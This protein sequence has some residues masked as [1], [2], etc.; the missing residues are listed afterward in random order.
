MT[1]NGYYNL[2]GYKYLYLN[3]TWYYYNH[4]W[5][6]WLV[7]LGGKWVKFIQGKRP[8]SPR[9]LKVNLIFKGK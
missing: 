5:C 3:G 9:N 8:A 1:K 4:N 7:H 6:I 2:Y